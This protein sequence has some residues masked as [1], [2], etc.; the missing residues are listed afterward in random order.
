MKAASVEVVELRSLESVI[1]SLS[2]VTEV[3]CK[4][5]PSNKALKAYIY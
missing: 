3:V 1:I 2:S 4:N 5:K